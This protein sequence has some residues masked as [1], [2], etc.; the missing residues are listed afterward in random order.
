MEKMS[1]ICEWMK[2]LPV[3]YYDFVK[4]YPGRAAFLWPVSLA[5][6]AWFF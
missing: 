1:K 2:Y 6:V 4:A 3:A 5:L